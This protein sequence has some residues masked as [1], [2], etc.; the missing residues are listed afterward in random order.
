MYVCTLR[1]RT[2]VLTAADFVSEAEPGQHVGMCQDRLAHVLAAHLDSS[3]TAL[4]R[5]LSSAEYRLIV[6]SGSSASG[7]WLS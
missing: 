7:L 3:A 2:P 4:E 1:Y 6:A 5:L